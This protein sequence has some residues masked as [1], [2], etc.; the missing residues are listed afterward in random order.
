[1]TDFRVTLKSNIKGVEL[2]KKKVKIDCYN[3]KAGQLVVATLNQNTAIFDGHKYD[4]KNA[5][6]ANDF[7]VKFDSKEAAEDFYDNLVTGVMNNKSVKTEESQKSGWQNFTAGIK[8]TVNTALATVTGAPADP[9]AP[10]VP[11]SPATTSLQDNGDDDSSSSS[12]MPL[13]IGGAV[14]LLVVIG[15]LVWKMKK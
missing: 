15:L 6:N 10:A 2:N 13:I 5:S 1:M 12:K 4:I 14:V 7:N 3:N 8:N 11:A 9:A